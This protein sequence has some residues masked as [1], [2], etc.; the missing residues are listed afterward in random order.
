MNKLPPRITSRTAVSIFLASSALLLGAC[1]SGNSDLPLAEDP[2]SVSIQLD[3][4]GC[5]VAVEPALLRVSR[6]KDQGA[7]WTVE[8]PEGQ[9]VEFSVYF[10]PFVDSNRG[11]RSK[12]GRL[13]SPKLGGDVP[14]NVKYKYTI[15]TKA[16][17]DAPL[18][19]DLM[20]TH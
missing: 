9:E 10:N 14:L 3:A 15:V 16:C 20:V 7:L 13:H 17:P 1:S 5:P 19:P 2:Q 8:A 4:K 18:D 6:S 12:G 11:L